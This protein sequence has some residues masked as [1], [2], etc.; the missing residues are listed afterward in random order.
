MA[1]GV[2]SGTV[3]F[4]FTDV[5]G[6]TR[7]WEEDPDAMRLAV[8]THDDLVR[9]AIQA[10]GGYVFA[11]GGD[12][13]AAA[14]ARTA[15]AVAAAQAAQAALVQLDGIAVRMGI[16]TGEVHER[17]GD[18][19]GPAVN[20]TARL[21]AAGHGG[22][23][24]ISGV[25]AELVPG[26]VLRNLG[27]RRLRDL[28]SPLLIWQLGT[29][30]F[31]PLRT[32]GELPGNLPVQLTS[33]VGR[34]AELSALTELLAA[35]RMVTLTGTGGV[36]KTRLAVHL[37][38]DLLDRYRDGVWLVELASVEGPRAL[39]VIAGA[40]GV[41]LRPARTFEDCVIEDLKS[42]QL[43]LVLDNCEHIVPE[44]R[45]IAELLLHQSPGLSI[46]ATSREGL[47]VPG[48]QLYSVPSLDDD[49]AQR[50]FLER[51]RSVDSEFT[52][53]ESDQTSV[54]AICNQL[55]GI[56]LA[57]ELAAARV[58][59]FS[60]TDLVQ[61]V[62]QRFRLLTGGRGTVERHQTLRAAI[63]WSYDLLGLPE[64]VAFSRLSVFAGGCTLEAAEAITAGPDVEAN[65]VLHL[66]SGPGRQ[67]IGDCGPHPGHHPLRH[68]GDDPPVRRGAPGCF[69]RRRGR[70]GSPRSLVRRLRSGRRSGP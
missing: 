41:D 53:G 58:P 24:L 36:G 68:V 44:V 26:L 33:F 3:T 50:L 5:E 59:M 52:P 37:A 38:A 30:E 31:P 56:P 48:E 39:E 25:T 60:V 7:R 16:N 8:A 70:P 57:I 62:R 63:D 42:R 1:V 27:E 4:L 47:R 67:V 18:Y 28:S 9:G 2:P 69:R 21:M 11:T 19:F 22:Q 14:F 20:R 64:R 13:F 23:V 40:V 51:A 49:S 43:L 15:D 54:L 6:S 32:L 66:L 45:R 61:R 34:E 55:D 35:H 29:T 65:E 17:D 46:L 12:G 10:N